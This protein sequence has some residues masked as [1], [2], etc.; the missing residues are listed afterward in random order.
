VAAA[1]LR[2]RLSGSPACP[3]ARAALELGPGAPGLVSVCVLTRDAHEFVEPC[4]RALLDTTRGLAV[5]IL[6]GDTGSSD[7]R[8][9]ALYEELAERV[10]VHALGP[11]HFSRNNNE[12]ARRGRGEFLLFLNND[13]L[14]PEPG[15]RSCSRRWREPRSGSSARGCCS[16]TARCSTRASRSRPRSRTDTSRCIG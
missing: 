15:S 2:A 8:V 5:E 10:E 7:P 6:V 3:A 12:L 14:R 13:T 11:Y 4:L 16:P 1:R 9:L